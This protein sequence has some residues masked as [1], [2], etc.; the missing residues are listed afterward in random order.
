MSAKLNIFG[1]PIQPQLKCKHCGKA[2]GDH[3]AKT[4]NCP[5]G[6]SRSFPQYRN[7]QTFEALDR[8]EGQS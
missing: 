5:F 8:K 4:F 6:R 1:E 2:K 7:N 3:L